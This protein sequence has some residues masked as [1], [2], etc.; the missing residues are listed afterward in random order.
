MAPP[1]SPAAK[2]ERLMN[3]VMTLLW[4]RRPLP[5]ARIREIVEQYRLAPSTEA[6]ER[7][8]ERDKEDLRELGIPLVTEDLNAAWDDEPGYRIHQRDYA[9]PDLAF[10]PDELAVLGLAA[11]TWSHATLAGPA[12][13][14]LRKLRASGVEPDPDTLAGIEPRLATSEPAFGPLVDALLDTAP[15]TF[16][17]R[18]PGTGEPTA[19]HVQPWGLTSRSGR[20]YLTG[21]D[22]DRDAP[23]VFRLSRIAGPV[24]R[25]GPGGSYAPPA[26]HDPRRMLAADLPAEPAAAAEVA[27]ADGRAHE[28]RRRATAAVVTSPGWSTLTLPYADADRLAEELASHGASVR[29][30]G[31][32]ALVE[33][34]RA[35]LAAAA[36]AGP[37]GPPVRGG[38]TS[39]GV[40]HEQ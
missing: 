9:L 39:R 3:L 37:G 18:R 35:V 38:R 22:T 11:R 25:T 1:N 8:F 16:A 32:P 19:R 36:A 29:A 27:V 23:R 4:T 15:V 26:D 40:R 30:V 6:F 2:T 24:T 12:A 7:M 13:Q 34:T 20:W 33:A 17:Y 5:K 28:L 21:L 31:P 14:A 10:T